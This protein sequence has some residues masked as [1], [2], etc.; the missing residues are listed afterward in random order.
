MDVPF[1]TTRHTIVD[2]ETQG[3]AAGPVE[4]LCVLHVALAFP[5]RCPTQ[6]P[7]LCSPVEG[8]GTVPG[9]FSPQMCLISVVNSE[10]KVGYRLTLG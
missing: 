3:G 5:G 7:Q 4:V 10:M 2:M 8:C 6:L 1:R 9:F